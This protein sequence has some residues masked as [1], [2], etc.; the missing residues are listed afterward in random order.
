G[1]NIGEGAA[2]FEPIHGS[3]PKYAGQNKVNPLATILSGVMMLEHLGEKEAA[4]RI[5]K[6]ILAVLAEG[7]YL[8]Y[9]LGGGAGTS[10]MADAIV[11]QL[12]GE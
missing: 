3:A 1:A 10:E 6:A 7:K 4:A 11:R 8:T 12:A 5:H 2:V 9:D